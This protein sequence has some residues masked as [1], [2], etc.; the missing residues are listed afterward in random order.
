MGRNI[1]D[2][3]CHPMVARLLL[4]G[5][6]ATS[7]DYKLSHT[8][9]FP[10]ASWSNSSFLQ[11]VTKCFDRTIQSLELATDALFSPTEQK[12]HIQRHLISIHNNHYHQVFTLQR[13]LYLYS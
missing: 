3:L 8:T 4:D 9:P 2:E 11:A 5:I 12:Y 1:D 13:I 6:P 10:Q 7:S